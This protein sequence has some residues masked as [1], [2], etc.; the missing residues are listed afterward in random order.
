ML[1]FLLGESEIAALRRTLRPTERFVASVDEHVTAP[2]F[3]EC[4]L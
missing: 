2:T 1:V 3:G 4:K